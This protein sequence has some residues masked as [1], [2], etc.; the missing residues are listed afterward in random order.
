MVERRERGRKEG[1]GDESLRE[2]IKKDEAGIR[3]KS[4]HLSNSCVGKR[5]QL[6][7]FSTYHVMQCLIK[8][9]VLSQF[10]KQK[11]RE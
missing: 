5:S 7:T 3:T 4:I 6:L 2:Q 1:E 10:G 9:F 11:I 8:C